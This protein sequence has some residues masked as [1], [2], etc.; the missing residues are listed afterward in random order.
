MLMDYTFALPAHLMQNPSSRGT[1]PRSP[2]KGGAVRF[3]SGAPGSAFGRHKIFETNILCDNRSN[4]SAAMP[5]ISNGVWSRAEVGPRPHSYFYTVS[6][7]YQDT[8]LRP[9]EAR[10]Y[11]S[12]GG[13]CVISTTI[14]GKHE[15]LI[16]SW[17]PS[18]KQLRRCWLRSSH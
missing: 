4:K 17:M 13:V 18:S 1:R 8:L 14:R 2:E 11:Y 9:G 10:E 3:C 16:R 5:A 15:C 7:L 6:I 12:G